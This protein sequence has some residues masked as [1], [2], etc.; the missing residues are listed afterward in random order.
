MKSHSLTATS[1]DALPDEQ[2]Y[3]LLVRGFRRLLAR[4]LEGLQEGQLVVS[5]A[6]GEQRFGQ[7]DAHCP[8]SVRVEVTDPEFY[9]LAV[10]R[11]HIGVAE[12]Y[13][14]GLWR[15][16]HLTDLIRLFVRNRAA[17]EAMEGGLAWLAQPLF[18]LY[19]WSRRNTRAGSRANIAAHYDL[20]NDFYRLFL[21]ETM[22]YSC[23]VY[24][25]AQSSLAEASRYKLECICQKLALQPED[26]LLEIGTG[27]GEMA[28]H[29]ARHYGCRVTTTTISQEQY[30][31]ALARVVDAGLEDRITVLCEDYRDLR[32]QYDK[33]VSVEMIEAVGH[34]FLDNYIQ[35]CSRLL[36]PQGIMLLQSITIADQHYEAAKRYGDFIQRYIFPGG[37]LPSVAALSDA[38]ARVSDMRL[39]HLED[40]GPHYARTLRD[41]RERFFASLEQVRELG[42][43]DTFVRMW[44][45][46]LCYCEGGFLER[47]IGT[48]QVLLVKPRNQREPLLPSMEGV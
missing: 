37:F 23:A 18:R 21:D 36:K 12:A 7:A 35:T 11:G 5:D 40:I 20:G 19:H 43:S 45:F 30:K 17:M 31:L 22:M 28:I 1:T 26:H 33:L 10:S 6:L 48:V 14:A 27:W 42:F 3:S 2:H 32:G 24:P 25:Q 4:S 16:D 9:R 39:F 41:W 29:A 8:L 13:M 47:H 44:E 15:C 38:V 34:Q 46:Y